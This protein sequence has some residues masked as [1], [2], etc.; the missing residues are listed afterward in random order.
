MLTKSETVG[1]FRV[2]YA[3]LSPR[4]RVRVKTVFQFRF[5]LD[6]V[7]PAAARLSTRS[8]ITRMVGAMKFSN[9]FFIK[10]I[11]F[12]KFLLLNEDETLELETN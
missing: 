8:D 7:R 4:V 5:K 9:I 1:T 3:A 6:Q 12:M 10:F 2:L 11:Q